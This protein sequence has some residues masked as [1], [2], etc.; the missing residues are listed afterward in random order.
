[1]LPVVADSFSSLIEHWLP[2]Y[3]LVPAPAMRDRM[4]QFLALIVDGQRKMRLVGSADPELLVRRHLGESVALTR[5]LRPPGHLVDLGS[6][7]GF[8]GLALALAWPDIKT[9]LV[10]ATLKK[11]RFLRAALA[12]L[13]LEQQV[14]VCDHF[15]SR[16]PPSS[17]RAPLA[18]ASLVTARALE[19]MDALP[20]WL[21]SWLDV[22]CQASFWISRE[23]AQAWRQRCPSWAWGEFFPLPGAERRG[24]VLAESVSR[25]TA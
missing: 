23:R 12:A 21:P 18:G 15:L 25:E 17:G 3:G 5:F 14:S 4:A 13:G 24:I 22:G 8:P 19:Q 16:R 10:E 9:T 7:A 20:D 2:D 1:M 6:G 11:A